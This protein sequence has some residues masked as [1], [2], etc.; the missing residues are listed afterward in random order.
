MGI[1]KG[2]FRVAREHVSL[3]GHDR[4]PARILLRWTRPA[5]K[6]VQFEPSL[7]VFVDRLEEYRGLGSMDQN[8]D[9]VSS[10]DLEYAVEARIVN[11]NA[12]ALGVLQIHA[13]ILEDLQA[14]RA[15]LDV[16]L[17]LIGRALAI[18]WLV[19]PVEVDV[20]EDCKPIFVVALQ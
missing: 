3:L 18:A 8:G 14:L 6:L 13:E 20:G 15:I 1:D 7:I 17:E 9:L 16:L 5:G 4:L 19:E 2:G 10:A 11:V 12:L